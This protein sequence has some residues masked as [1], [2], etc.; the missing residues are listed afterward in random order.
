MKSS[1]ALHRI[2]FWT[3][4]GL[5]FVV[6]LFF[7]PVTSEYYEFNKQALLVIAGLVLLALLAASFITEKTVRVV[8]SPLGLP[9]LGLVASWLIS[10][11]LKTPNRWD[12]FTDPSQTTTIVALAIFFVAGINF[13][14][15]KKDLELAFGS[16]LASSGVLALLSL[17]WG[18]NLFSKFLPLAFLKSPLW[19]PTGSPLGALLFLTMIAI[20]LGLLAVKNRSQLLGNFKHLSVL[21]LSILAVGLLTFKLF[22]PKST[23]KPLFLP[24]NTS[25][26]IAL[27]ALKTAPIWGTGSDTYLSDFTRFRPA[28]FNL[29]NTW[30]I[31]FN[32]SSN[33]YLQILTTLGMVGLAAYLFLFVKVFHMAIKSIHLTSESSATPIAFSLPVTVLIYMVSLLF[34][35]PAFVNLF[36][37]FTLLILATAAFRVLGSNLVHDANIDIVAASENGIRSP[38]LPWIF[39]ALVV[40]LIAS[41]A[42]FGSKIYLAEFY[43][44]QS[45]NAAASNQAKETYNLLVKALTTNPRKDTYRLAYSQTNMILANSLAGKQ[46]ITAEERN[47]VTQLIQQSIQEAKNGVALNPGKV[48]NVENL[49]GIYRSLLGVAQG[50]DS[51]TVASYRQAILLDPTNPNLR[52]ALG[53]VLYAL[54]NYDDAIRIFQQAADLKSDL[55]NT[56]YNLSAAYREKGDFQNAFTTMQVVTNLVDKSSADYTKAVSE[57]EELRKK[58]PQ[59]A[60]TPAPVA[61]QKTELEAPKPIPSPKTT[62]IKLPAELGPEITPSPAPSTP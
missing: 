25:W 1:Q 43:F 8:R 49:A 46:N 44:G 34:V 3:V 55:P 10:T 18:S 41:T 33:Y 27:E 26:A 50:A 20:S 28:A 31:R 32:S 37:M 2:G 58:L 30:N 14:R 21:V 36:L 56:Y 17:L 45:L 4:V 15:T 54:K 52:V 59:A 12:A 40:A 13:I 61:P 6:P 48:T 35:P 47:T 24:Q 16:L 9:V 39:A 51:W 19:T 22:S 7:L 53:G 42:F 62:P 57:L 11:F 23:S 38:I 29:T 60:A 5:I